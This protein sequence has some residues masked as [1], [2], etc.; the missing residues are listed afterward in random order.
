MSVFGEKLNELEQTARLVLDMD[1]IALTEALRRGAGRPAIAVGSGGS[2][3]A[4]EFLAHCRSSLQRAQ[5]M[6]ETPLAFVLG[7]GDIAGAQVWLFSGRGENSD[8]IATLQSAR[9]RRA[10]E[11]IVV[12]TNS[13]SRL[14][15]EGAEAAN[16]TIISLP[17]WS[18][19]DSFLAT[20]SLL[21]TAIALL[22]ASAQSVDGAALE[23]GEVRSCVERLLDHSYRESLADRFKGLKASDTIV[24]LA[25]PRLGTLATLIETSVWEIALCAVQ[26]TDFR[27]FAHG[28]HVLLAQRPDDVWVFAMTGIETREAWS[29]IKQHFPESLRVIEYDFGNCGRFD[30]FAGLLQGLCLI[31]AMGFARG[32][33]PG[34]PGIGPFARDIYEA[35]SLER[36]SRRLSRPMRHK[37]RAVATYDSSPARSVDFAAA[38]AS[39]KA[40]LDQ[41]AFSGLVLD[42]DGTIITDQERESPPRQEILDEL[43]RLIE[44]GIAIALATGRGGS[45]GQTL[46][47]C[48]KPT[49]QERFLI[50]Y[51]NG[52]YLRSLDVDIEVDK[53]A[54]ANEIGEV[55]A[56]LHEH[57]AL[58]DGGVPKKV[59]DST[60]QISL[61]LSQL[62]NPGSF[63]PL[64]RAR[65]GDESGVKVVRSGHS[66]DITLAS[67]CKTNVIRAMCDQIGEADAAILSVGDRGELG[68]NDHVLLGSEYGISVEHVCDRPEV[69][70]SIFGE[71]RIGPEA[72]LQILRC[73]VPE[74]GKAR[75]ILAED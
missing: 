20:H 22:L 6:I 49:H 72:L 37:L 21:A 29:D 9:D 31:E 34:R 71:H 61:K 70:W 69:C 17:T 62:F 25:D 14:A 28:R 8:V 38:H 74:A 45:V 47:K 27:N 40:K 59:D 5:T 63:P 36:L 30:V 58:F 75:L 64:F 42:Y 11:I 43:E 10:G 4:A 3:I 54:R 24:L 2:A 66:F 55:I 19:K 13:T 50:G 16:T 41:A 73:L 68:G 33:D 39:F 18:E 53:P 67:T 57:A 65:F 35:S 15:L 7:S 32:I 46:R 51:Y 23:V 44:G 48:V 60:V 1:L 26:R 12:T 52:A 56:W